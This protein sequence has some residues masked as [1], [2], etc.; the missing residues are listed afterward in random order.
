[1]TSGTS[2]FYSPVTGDVVAELAK[3]SAG[4]I[5]ESEEFAEVERKLEEAKARAG[6]IR[7]QEIL[8]ESEESTNEE[9]ADEDETNEEEADEDEPT[10][11]RLEAIE[12]LRDY[13]KL[14]HTSSAET[15]TAEVT[16]P[17]MSEL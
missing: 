17:P 7:L 13:V 16:K 9:E 5:A 10:I 1:M 14:L 12:I 15:L 3:R 6:V 8:D 4:R 2:Q 11:Q